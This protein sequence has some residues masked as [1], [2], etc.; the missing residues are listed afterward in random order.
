[1]VISFKIGKQHFFPPRLSVI[2]NR[3]MPLI[4]LWHQSN[5]PSPSMTTAIF[6]FESTEIPKAT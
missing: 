4:D 3:T 1:M 6:S 2:L 5:F